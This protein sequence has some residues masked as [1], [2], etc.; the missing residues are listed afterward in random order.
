MPLKIAVWKCKVRNRKF[1][2]LKE[3]CEFKVNNHLIVCD[4]NS[5]NKTCLHVLDC[6]TYAYLM[7][8]DLDINNEICGICVNKDENLICILDRENAKLYLINKDYKIIKQKRIERSINIER[9]FY[10]GIDYNCFNHIYYIIDA[11]L[12]NKTI[13]M[14]NSE[15]DFIV[16]EENVA[17]CCHLES[18]KILNNKVYVCDHDL[19]NDK[20]K[21]RIMVFDCELNYLH[22]ICENSLSN[23]INLLL[24]PKNVN[25]IYVLENTSH[26]NTVSNG[27]I[28]VFDVNNGKFMYKIFIKKY[29]NSGTIS[30]GK[31]M[32][33]S[34]FGHEFHVY[35]FIN[36]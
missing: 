21:N 24:N 36:R 28:K 14:W 2:R 26:L 16:K 25:F 27:Y 7:K 32:L 22:S 11:T 15:L 20:S 6:N 12:G 13:L 34:V 17:E 10:K 35:D 19:W 4:S 9:R 8:I 3:I 1:D 5:L 30:S 31:L 29:F 18:I 23:P 33:T